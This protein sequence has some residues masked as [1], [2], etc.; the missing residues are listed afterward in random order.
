MIN[1]YALGAS[2]KVL[3]SGTAYWQKEFSNTKQ[4][5]SPYPRVWD[6]L[7]EYQP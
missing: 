6:V 2:I 1:Y 3:I 7:S 5:I 4:F